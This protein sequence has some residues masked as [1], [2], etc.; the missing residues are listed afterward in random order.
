MAKA[1]KRKD[2]RYQIHFRVDGKSFTVIG[3]TV[4]EVREKE[5]MKREEIAKGIDSR[6]GNI[7]LDEYFKEW[8]TQKEGTVKPITVRSYENIYRLHISPVLGK[9]KIGKITRRE[10]LQW[11]VAMA[12]GKSAGTIKLI[13]TVFLQIMREARRGALITNLNAVEDLPPLRVKGERRPARETIHRALTAEEV[14]VFLRYARKSWY[15]NAIRFMLN[16]GVRAG[17]CA[18]LQWKDIDFKNG[19]IHIRRTT[20][21]D[22]K[23]RPVMSDSPKT[24]TSRRDIPMNETIRMILQEQLEIGR[25]FW[26]NVIPFDGS[27]IVFPS[28]RGGLW[29][30]WQAWAICR[31]I[32]KRMKAD[33]VN[34]ERFSLHATRDTFISMKLKNGVPINTVKEI[35]GH[36]SLAMTA[37]LYGHVYEE[38]KRAAMQAVNGQF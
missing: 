13:C 5:R 3:G 2:R 14:E 20:T 30:S 12:E 26:G 1:T 7:T 36:A 32:F 18:G 23:Y 28:P 10:V 33:G 19:M 16:T 22:R 21:R 8:I 37:D 17:E 11:R 35:A 38:E 6:T 27:R 25:G 15:Y 29:G 4:K 24:K 31:G 34:I 9:R